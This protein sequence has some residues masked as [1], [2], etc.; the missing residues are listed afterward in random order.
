MFI[1]YVVDDSYAYMVLYKSA[2]L[3]KAKID[4]G[5]IVGHRLIENSL[6]QGLF[7]RVID[8]GKTIT[9]IPS[10]AKEF[11]IVDKDTCMIDRLPIPMIEMSK[12]EYAYFGDGFFYGRYVY[13]IG[14]TYPGIVRIDTMKKETTVVAQLKT[15]GCE[16]MLASNCHVGSNIYIPLHDKSGIVEFDC[17]T[18][19]LRLIEINNS[20]I[21]YFNTIL[22][23]GN[24]FWLISNDDKV[25]KCDKNFNCL[26]HDLDLERIIE[27]KGAF[28]SIFFQG[29]IYLFFFNDNKILKY[30][31]FKNYDYKWLTMGATNDNSR[32]VY[33]TVLKESGPCFYSESRDGFYRIIDD[34]RIVLDN[35]I[36]GKEFIQA[37][38]TYK[39]TICE[40]DAVSLSEYLNC[41]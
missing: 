39:N 18:E 12:Q 2:L 14:L 36:S 38:L 22:Y 10:N 19:S 20:D 4:S 3:I 41:I 34:D 35:I 27:K 9:F 5:E 33:Y 17:S 1:D 30:S 31:P 29:Y 28:R 11:V 15:I 25:F 16:G 37:Y 7:N 32:L 6:K 23:D 13:A 21:E 40:S 26:E 24:Y 8:C